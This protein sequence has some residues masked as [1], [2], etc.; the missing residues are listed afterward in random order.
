[1]LDEVDIRQK[2]RDRLLTVS[3]LPKLAWE[4]R[5]FTTP[6]PEI[7]NEYLEEYQ[8]ILTEQQLTSEQ[9]TVTG[10]TSYMVYVPTGSSIEALNGFTKDIADAF[11]PGQSL[12]TVDGV[13]QGC[14]V[15]LWRTTRTGAV[16]DRASEA[17][18]FQSVRI[19]WRVHVDNPNTP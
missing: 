15:V 12:R 6:T 4:N 19:A 2:M 9:V 7:G 10:L 8:E 18:Y 17:W 5:P 3:P 14:P 13:P 1:M 11:A 16:K